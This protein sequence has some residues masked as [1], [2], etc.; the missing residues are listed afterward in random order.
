MEIVPVFFAEVVVPEFALEKALAIRYLLGI[1]VL[2][3]SDPPRPSH[4]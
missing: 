1:T 3:T 2:L 4:F